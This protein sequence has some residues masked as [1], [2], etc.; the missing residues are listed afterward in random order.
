MQKIFIVFFGLLIIVASSILWLSN[1]T[2]L[3]KGVDAGAITAT[4]GSPWI[5]SLFTDETEKMTNRKIAA[6]T[7]FALVAEEIGVS[8]EETLSILEASK[9]KYNLAKIVEGRQISFV[10][11]RET[12]VFN[13][14]IYQINADE[15]LAVQKTTDNTWTAERTAI[16]YEIE[17]EEIEG[18]IESS[19]FETI[20]NSGGDERIALALSEVFAWQIDF[21]VDIRVEDS[22]KLVYEKRMLNGNYMGPGNILAAKFIN[23]G[24]EYKGIYFASENSKAGYYDMEGNSLQKIF[25]K[26][27]LSYKYISSGFSYNRLNPVTRSFHAHRAIDYAAPTGTP[28]ISVGDGTVTLA[29][30]NGA[31]GNTIKVR[32]NETYTTLYA[33]LSK[34]AVNSGSKVKQGQI[35]GYVGSTGQSTGPHL[36]FEMYKNGSHTNPLTIELPP[37][38]PIDKTEKALFENKIQQYQNLFSST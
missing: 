28:I 3:G 36:H 31:Y 11:D 22:F 34:F 15:I 1:N 13:K 16:P 4:I 37:G 2:G 24:A 12:G 18:T 20:I 26:S 19:L 17:A 23:D 7:V 6:G 25:L 30:W 33:H 9:E 29:G 35:I 10:S 38:E 14:V 5:G 32:H 21:A 27:P 8:P